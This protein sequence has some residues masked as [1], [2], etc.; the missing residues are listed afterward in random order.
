MAKLR[1]S[2]KTIE[3]VSQPREGG[4]EP[5]GGERVQGRGCRGE[6]RR[7]CL[8]LPACRAVVIGTD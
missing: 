8:K 1:I 5:G 6:G 3:V 2:E 7:C 4:A